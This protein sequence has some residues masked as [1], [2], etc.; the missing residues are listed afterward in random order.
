MEVEG[1][2]ELDAAPI[3]ASELRDRML[4]GVPICTPSFAVNSSTT[5]F[6]CEPLQITTKCRMDLF[7]QLDPQDENYCRQD[8]RS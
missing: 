4:A 3:R 5:G 8:G 7:I 6:K 2:V 1:V